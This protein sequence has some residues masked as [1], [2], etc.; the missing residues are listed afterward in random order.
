MPRVYLLTGVTG[1]LGKVVL[2]ELL[3]RREEF[4]LERVRLLIRPRGATSPAERFVREVAPSACFS[5]LPS[6]WQGLVEVVSASLEEPDLGLEAQAAAAITANTTHILHAAASVDFGLPLGDAVRAN[7]TT[8]LT[9]L[10][11]ARRCRVL[12]KLVYVSTAYVAPHRGAKVPIEETLAPLPWPAER[13][14]RDVLAGP[15]HESALLQAAGHPNTYT[16]TKCLAEHLLLGRAGEVPLAVVRPSIISASRCHPHQGWI[17]SI[18]GFAAFVVML[19]Q[20]HLRV[21]RGHPRARLDLVP[22]D[23]VSSRILAVAHA[24]ATR[25]Q[26]VITHAVAGLE[27]SPTV[28]QCWEGIRDYYRVHP[29]GGR[30]PRLWYLGPPGFPLRLAQLLDDR[31]ALLTGNGNDR[32]RRAGTSVRNRADQ[33]NRQFGYFVERSFNFQTAAPLGANF[34][35]AEYVSLVCRGVARHLQ[36]QDDRECIVAGRQHRHYTGDFG[37]AFRQPRGN[38][39]I[40]MGGWGLTKVLRRTLDRV[41]IDE[42]SFTTALAKVP[43]G[44]TLV[45]VATHRSYLDFVLC[46][47][48]TFSR[49]DLRIPIPHVAAASDFNRIPLLGRLLPKAHAFYLA[50]GPR[51]ENA[52]LGRRI[53]RMLEAGK[54]IEFYIEGTRSRTR[55]FLPPK[56][57]LLRLLLESGHDLVLLPI[58]ISFE[59]VPEEPVFVRELNGEPKPRMRFVG[60]LTWLR[61]AFRGDVRLG[62]AHLAAG[63]PVPL[64]PGSDLK[65]VSDEIMDQLRAATVSTTWHL[66]TYLQHH[67]I[68]GVD[69]EWLRRT[70]ESRGGRVLESELP[71]GT[72]DPRLAPDLRHHFAHLFRP[73]EPREGPLG[74]LLDALYGPTRPASSPPVPERVA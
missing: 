41:T 36:G 19:G 73:D 29:V 17:D 52:Q 47:Y 16:L 2:E 45:L 61:E 6:G 23:E 37:W 56:R 48:L 13:I 31:L 20:G 74:N 58:A 53:A 27:G 62:R 55:E 49:P 15:T 64:P 28:R 22:A 11:L 70:I 30:R 42:A 14:Y 67:P 1:F 10:E 72:L 63:T 65:R 33:L 4:G 71:V 46:T 38:L 8:T 57:G 25:G 21:V 43:P 24:P 5:Q 9:L 69:A 40:R 44:S 18:S 12:E 51:R 39:L 54:T 60:F 59:R 34:S 68:A 7:V 50:R 66:E 35:P 3:R 32:S 26:T